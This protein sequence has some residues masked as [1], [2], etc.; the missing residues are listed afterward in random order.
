MWTYSFLPSRPSKRGRTSLHMFCLPT[1]RPLRAGSH[2]Y[3]DVLL[4]TFRPSGPPLQPPQPPLQHP[5]A[6]YAAARR[7][8]CHPLRRQRNGQP[9]APR[10]PMHRATP[11]QRYPLRRATSCCHCCPARHAAALAAPQISPLCLP[12]PRSLPRG[13][14]REPGSR[15]AARAPAG[16][17]PPLL[18][19]HC[20]P[21]PGNYGQPQNR[22]GFTVASRWLRRS[23]V[24]FVELRTVLP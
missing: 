18:L 10:H 16:I 2:I 24:A 15:C 13:R 11:A 1:S 14:R 21:C 20:P 9:P 23:A 4:P 8:P 7:R 19:P 22:G 6:P 3:V 5:A 17:R 12:P